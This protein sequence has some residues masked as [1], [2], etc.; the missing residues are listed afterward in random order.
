MATGPALTILTIAGTAIS[1]VGTIAAG[2]AQ[3][4]MA[5]YQAK[6]YEIKAQEEKAQ[7]AQ[8]EQALLKKLAYAQSRNRAVNAASGF[9]TSDP[10]ALD[11]AGDLGAYGTL[12]AEM[13]QYGGQSRA[14][15]YL[16]EAALK[17]AEGR[18]A[19]TGSYFNAASTIIGG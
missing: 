17:R 7:G 14:Q 2:N 18:S 13:A 4:A 9:S 16:E 10:T 19:V 1:A 11:I 5:Q 15:G 6:V 3:N 8:E 12:Q